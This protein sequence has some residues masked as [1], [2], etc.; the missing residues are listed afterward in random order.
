MIFS[1]E[2]E[3]FSDFAGALGKLLGILSQHQSELTP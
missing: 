3:E 2:N 1:F